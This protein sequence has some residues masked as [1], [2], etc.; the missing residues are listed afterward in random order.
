MEEWAEGGKRAGHCG[1]GMMET[2][3]DREI[4]DRGV[5]GGIYLL[6]PFI[7]LQ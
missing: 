3:G 7:Y 1:I 6:P 2:R 5:R 4:S